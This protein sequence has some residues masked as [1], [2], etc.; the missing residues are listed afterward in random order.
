ML[1]VHDPDNYRTEI[2]SHTCGFHRLHPGEPYAG[3]ACSTS[4][5]SCAC[6][7][8]TLTLASIAAWCGVRR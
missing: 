3:C 2:K 7:C 6:S 1:Y 8:T 5:G 4:F